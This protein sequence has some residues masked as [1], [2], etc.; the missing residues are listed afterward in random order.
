MMVPFLLQESLVLQLPSALDNANSVG[1][2]L[3]D[4][5]TD[6]Q[7]S[8]APVPFLSFLFALGRRSCNSESRKRCV[9]LLSCNDLGLFPFCRRR[10]EEAVSAVIVCFSIHI[11]DF[12]SGMDGWMDGGKARPGQGYAMQHKRNDDGYLHSF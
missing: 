3:F 10:K 2:L 11:L 8:L 5:L 7:A 1:A 12:L 4:C 9:L 6:L